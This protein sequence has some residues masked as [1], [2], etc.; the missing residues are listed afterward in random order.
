VYRHSVIFLFSGLT[1]LIVRPNQ[2]LKPLGMKLARKF[3]ARWFKHA[4]RSD[5]QD[6]KIYEAVRVDVA[7]ALRI[8]FDE[9]L[10]GQTATLRPSRG[11]TLH[12]IAA[13]QH[14]TV[15]A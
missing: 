14:H 7:R 15:W 3:V 10:L 13:R 1:S 11:L 8:R 6:F 2:S 9:L 4:T 12:L 5:L